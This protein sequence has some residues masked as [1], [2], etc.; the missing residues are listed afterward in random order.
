MKVI[1]GIVTE[2]GDVFIK[3]SSRPEATH[4][5]LFPFACGDCFRYVGDTVYWWTY[6]TDYITKAIELADDYL[7]RKGYPQRRKHK[8]LCA[9]DYKIEVDRFRATHGMSGRQ[10]CKLLV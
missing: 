8:P 5:E 3:A 4:T 9:C 7:D 1:F 10:F 6:N 2:D